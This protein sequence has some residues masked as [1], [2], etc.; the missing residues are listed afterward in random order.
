MSK[1]E[2]LRMAIDTD[3]LESA[4]KL[5]SEDRE[6]ANSRE[7]TPPPLHLAVY[8]NKPLMIDLLLDH[9]ADIEIKDQDRSTTPVR[10]AIVYARQDIIRQLVSRGANVGA[11]QEN[12]TTALEVAKKGAAGGFEEYKELPSREEY[13]EIVKLLE[14]LTD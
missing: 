9:G 3:D 14:E 1:I 2:S 13:G 12:G 10:Y 8:L 6:L 11:I 4:G 7:K 5:L